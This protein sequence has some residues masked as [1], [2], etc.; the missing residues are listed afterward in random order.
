MSIETEFAMTRND[1]TDRR[2]F[3]STVCGGGI[4]AAFAHVAFSGL[5][6][7][8]TQPGETQP[9]EAQSG[10]TRVGETAAKESQPGP[11]TPREGH[12]PAKAKHC[13]FLTME[14]GPSHIDTFDPKP[15]LAE[16]CICRSLAEAGNKNRQWKV[17]VA[18]TSR[19]RSDSPSTARAERTW[20]TIGSIF[21]RSPISCASIVVVKST[22]SI[23]RLRCIKSI[24]ATDSAVT[25][26]SDLGS[27]MDSDRKTKTCPASS[28]FRRSRIR[29]EVQRTG[30]TDICPPFI[31][32]PRYA[33]RALPSSIC[34]HRRDSPGSDN[35]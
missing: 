20:P 2:H 33:R 9:G 7:N 24:A 25:P 23:I 5:L 31:K 12:F 15:S 8:E 32:A 14:G 29:K 3:L 21:P 19:A 18:T 1:A 34:N 10:E 22:A 4:G 11:L 30:A 16:T 6:A 26:G 35:E 27:L 28:S 17:G 13:I